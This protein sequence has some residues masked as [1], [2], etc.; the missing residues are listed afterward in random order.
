M[1]RIL[2]VTAFALV[3]APVLAIAADFPLTEKNTAVKFIGAKPKG[4]HEGGFK[5]VTG[6]ASVD[7]ADLTTLKIS[8]DIDTD[9][10]YTDNEK[11]TAHLKSPDF[12]GVKSNPKA[13]FVSTKVEKSGD[14]HKI[15]GDLTLLG[16]T[17]SITFPATVSVADGGLNLS[18]SF[19]I[20]R[21]QWGMT[22]GPGKVDNDVKLTVSVK[23][24]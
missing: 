3:L 21:T 4:K 19:T 17:K 10:L 12:F 8:L 14:S 7:G 2:C 6:N 13:K 24:K 11:L 23:T 1:R 5:A 22:Y 16:K 9:S 15:T 20:D 18:S